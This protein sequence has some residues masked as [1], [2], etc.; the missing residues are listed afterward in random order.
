[1]TILYLLPPSF[2]SDRPVSHNAPVGLIK[3]INRM[4]L[5]RESAFFI[6]LFLYG[7]LLF[8]HEFRDHHELKN[9]FCIYSD[10]LLSFRQTGSL[11]MNGF[12]FSLLERTNPYGKMH[13]MPGVMAL[14]RNVCI[15]GNAHHHVIGFR[16]SNQ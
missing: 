11:S 8:M 4:V 2:R 12:C 15:P 1:M 14:G 6:F 9:P 13:A 3:R 16:L 7:L 5:K 10:N